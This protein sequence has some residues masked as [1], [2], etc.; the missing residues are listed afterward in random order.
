MWKTSY[1]TIR[2]K[3]EDS[4]KGQRWEFDKIRLFSESDYM[5]KVCGDLRDVAMVRII[6]IEF[7][8]SYCYSS[9]AGY[10]NEY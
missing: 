5:A 9:I 8:L 7:N 3:I 10:N 4:G 1:L 2:Q 6:L